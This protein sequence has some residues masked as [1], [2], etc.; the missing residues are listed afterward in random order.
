MHLLFAAI[1]DY[2]YVLPMTSPDQKSQKHSEFNLRAKIMCC[3]KNFGTFYC[4]RPEHYVPTKSPGSW[5]MSTHKI[6]VSTSH[7]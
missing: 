2:I 7:T 3:K 6:K 4:G 1:D 5:R